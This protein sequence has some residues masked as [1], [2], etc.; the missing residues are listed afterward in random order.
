[1]LGD[2]CVLEDWKADVVA[3]CR[4]RSIT[5]WAISCEPKILGVRAYAIW[6]A[7]LADLQAGSGT[8]PPSF[9]FSRVTR[10]LDCWFCIPSLNAPAMPQSRRTGVVR[11]DKRTRVRCYGEDT[12]GGPWYGYCQ[13]QGATQGSLAV[14]SLG[15]ASDECIC[16]RGHCTPPTARPI[17]TTYG[18]GSLEVKL[19]QMVSRMRRS[20]ARR[21]CRSCSTF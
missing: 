13:S 17:F 7:D 8:A 16:I 6:Q 11:P 1:M 5:V 18:N 20:I 19:K 12:A 2:V 4:S 15:R 14:C 9:R 10:L 3:S 21:R